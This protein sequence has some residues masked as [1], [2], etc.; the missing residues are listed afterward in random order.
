MSKYVSKT[1]NTDQSLRCFITSLLKDPEFDRHIKGE[2]APFL[3]ANDSPE[4]SSTLPWDTGKAVQ[5]IENNEQR[6]KIE[7]KMKELENSNTNNP[8]EKAKK[9]ST[10]F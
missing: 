5:K 6:V 7:Q 2:W 9:T 8:P 1:V 10:I 3:G 4:T